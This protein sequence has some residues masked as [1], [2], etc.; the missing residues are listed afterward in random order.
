MGGPGVN[1]TTIWHATLA[2]GRRTKRSCKNSHY[3]T[4]LEANGGQRQLQQPALRHIP[5][6]DAEVGAFRC[7]P[8]AVERAAFVLPVR[9]NAID[10]D[11]VVGQPMTQRRP[12]A[13]IGRP[14]LQQAV[15]DQL[16]ERRRP[17]AVPRR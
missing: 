6:R 8:L 2:T 14:L 12:V 5:H 16:I 4:A 11:A 17:V 13:R 10:D 1:A 3:A 15:R 7:P 9:G